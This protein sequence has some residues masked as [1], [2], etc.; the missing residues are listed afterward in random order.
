[1]NCSSSCAACWR[2][3]PQRQI[4]EQDNAVLAQHRRALLALS[5]D[6]GARLR[7]SDQNATGVTL[8]VRYADASPTRRSRTLSE[9]TQHT[10]LL[11]RTAYTLYDSLGPQ[12]HAARLRC[13]E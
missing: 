4:I 5:D 9:A 8:T 12:H 10:V 6:L 7:T 3:S 11:A 2:T 1:M 13:G